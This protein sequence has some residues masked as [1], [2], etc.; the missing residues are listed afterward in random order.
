M[1]RTNKHY[2]PEEI[3]Q[4]RFWAN[5]KGLSS[6][7]ASGNRKKAEAIMLFGQ[8]YFPE[9]FPSAHPKLHTDILSIMNSASSLKAVASP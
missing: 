8:T 9:F 2:E 6:L 1:N 3:F 7:E 5:E 4:S